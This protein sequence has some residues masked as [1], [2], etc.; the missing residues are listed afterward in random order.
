MGPSGCGKTTLLRILAGLIPPDNGTIAIDWETI[1]GPDARVAMVFQDDALFPWKT[2]L[3]NV[4]FGK[5][6]D[7]ESL[8]TKR[9]SAQM[10]LRLINLSE[11]EGYYPHQLSGGQRQR[12]GV[13][14]A[15]AYAP[16]LLLMDEPFGALDGLTR[17]S[18]QED[19]SVLLAQAGT[20]AILV[21]HDISEA[22]YL[23]DKI[24]AFDGSRND[25]CEV[26]S[27]LCP[28]P[29]PPR[30]RYGAEFI[31]MEQ[32]VW[33]HLSVEGNNTGGLR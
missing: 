15:L 16:K 7:Q 28:R 25:L 27:V 13:A 8:A 10:L 21:T 12:V 26:V 33:A 3:D 6:T 14:R 18:L 31:E 2:A 32:M 5:R 23:A 11:K 22:I 29:R 19:V 24:F 17:M 30:F 20:S 1:H 9:S 4:V